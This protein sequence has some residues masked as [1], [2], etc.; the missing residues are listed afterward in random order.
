M[1]GR[2]LPYRAPCH[3]L[4]AALPIAQAKGCRPRWN[5]LAT[6]L[7]LALLAQTWYF[8]IGRKSQDL[9]R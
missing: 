7:D 6:D 4:A 1:K 9:G 5:R 8:S 3:L 2:L